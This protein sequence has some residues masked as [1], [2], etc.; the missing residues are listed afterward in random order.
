MTSKLTPVQVV[1]RGSGGKTRGTTVFHCGCG[2]SAECP[3]RS[4]M[5]KD[6]V[7]MMYWR[8]GAG[9]YGSCLMKDNIYCPRC[10]WEN[11]VGPNLGFTGTTKP[12]AMRMLPPPAKKK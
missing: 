3:E 8:G 1:R 9:E 12:A 11:R 4:V 10:A 6:W 5:P 7:H 2:A